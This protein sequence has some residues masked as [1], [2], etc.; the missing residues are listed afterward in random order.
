[1]GKGADE[2]EGPG[3]GGEEAGE[4]T[5]GTVSHGVGKGTDKVEGQGGGS[6]EAGEVTPGT[7]SHGVG[8]GTDEVEGQ[9]GGGGRSHAGNGE[10]WRGKGNRRG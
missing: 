9:G 3:G 7:V 6:E 2:V 10:S 4:V 8:K 1:M 5:P